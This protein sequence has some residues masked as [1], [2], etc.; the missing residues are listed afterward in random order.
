MADLQEALN[1]QDRV[2]KSTDLP[3]FFGQKDKDKVPP[4]LLLDRNNR[5]ATAAQ[6][7]TDERKITEFYLTLRD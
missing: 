1:A 5:A 6:W 4:N 3:L 7:N 2:R